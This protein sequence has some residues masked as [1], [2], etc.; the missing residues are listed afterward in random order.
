[1]DWLTYWF[2]EVLFLEELGLVIT[3]RTSISL[4][5]NINSLKSRPV[6]KTFAETNC[7]KNI[8]KN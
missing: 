3:F 6:V 2:F 8:E 5:R 4:A 1:M 7:E